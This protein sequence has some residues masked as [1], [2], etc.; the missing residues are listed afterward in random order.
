MKK[1]MIA[2]AAAAMVGGAF[3][4]NVCDTEDPKADT[5]GQRVYDVQIKVK[6]L[7]T[8]SGSTT[9]TS[10]DC[11]GGKTT[12]KVYDYYRVQ[13]SHTFK[14]VI[15]DCKTCGQELDPDGKLTEKTGDQLAMSEAQLYIAS[16]ADKYVKIYNAATFS[17]D[18]TAKGYDV[19]LLNF[20]NG[21]TFAKS[22]KAEMSIAFYFGE[23]EDSLDHMRYYSIMAAGFG[24]RDGYFLKNASG[25]CAGEVTTSCYC[26]YY[27]QVFEPC[28]GEGFYTWVL[29][30]DGVL[31]Q[32]VTSYEWFLKRS[33]FYDAVS[34]TWSIKYSSSKSKLATQDAVMKKTFKDYKAANI[35][36]PAITPDFP[37]TVTYLGK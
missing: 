29:N 24:A 18:D 30:A 1:L 28:T 33:P 3:A 15:I 21:V 4:N 7:D 34:G 31:E 20:Y 36:A 10:Q 19:G 13:K 22:T 25:N 26:G 27:G 8:K 35:M 6:T 5:L 14:G 32:D 9:T 23:R 12:T 37:F 16:A 11:W 17:G 2:A